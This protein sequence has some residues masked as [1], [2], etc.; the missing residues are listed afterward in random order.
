MAEPDTQPGVEADGER[1]LVFTA[2]GRR[3]AVAI[4]AV[5]EIVPYRVATRLPGAPAHVLGLINLR[6]RLV[7]VTDLAVQLGSRAA[8]GERSTGGSIILVGSGA[9]TVGMMVDDVRDVRPIVS[10]TV[11]PIQRDEGTPGLLQSLARFDDGV[12]VI[13]DMHALVANIL[14]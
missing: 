14:Q 10:G 7:T 2:D 8:G 3:Y 1:L 5:K 13:L 11:E 6:G 4:E 9:R 12:A